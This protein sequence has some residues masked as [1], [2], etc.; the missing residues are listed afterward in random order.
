MQEQVGSTRKQSSDLKAP[1]SSYIQACF[2]VRTL[3]VS[4]TLPTPIV[5]DALPLSVMSPNFMQMG[6]GPL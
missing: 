2:P 6:I 3:S 5:D 1:V 4:L